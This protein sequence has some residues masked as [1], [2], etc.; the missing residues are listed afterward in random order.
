MQSN[1]SVISLLNN[2]HYKYQSL[3][4]TPIAQHIE[5]NSI[6][7]LLTPPETPFFFQPINPK[8]KSKDF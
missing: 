4:H 1:E 7:Q 2:L 5:S 8:K 6:Y 3:I